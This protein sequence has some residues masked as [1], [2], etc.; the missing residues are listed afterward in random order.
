MGPGSRL[1]CRR[2]DTGRD[3]V[4][5][6]A[7]EMPEKGGSSLMTSAAL[8]LRAHSGWAA[9]IVVT[10]SPCSPR[11]VDRRRIELA[12]A[13]IPGSKQPYHTAQGLDLKA[14]E[15]FVAGCAA[16]AS[17]LAGRAFK[18]V[19]HNLAERRCKV[20]GCG[21]LFARGRSATTLG[22]TLASHALIHTAEGE[23]FRGA[24]AQASQQANLPLTRVFERELYA[25]GAAELS[26]PVG[27]LK[28]RLIELGQPIGP[29]WRQDEKYAA[30]VG[31]LA[32]SAGAGGT[33]RQDFTT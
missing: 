13:L 22:A 29:P 21:I 1:S 5:E 7:N 30:L 17:R 32:L 26:I 23:L 3:G 6:G 9:L 11:V 8:G 14:A 4:S 18:T 28:R 24:L 2:A 10:G 12:D 25:R 16:Q 20:I 31:W 33:G 19:I 15:K 27:E